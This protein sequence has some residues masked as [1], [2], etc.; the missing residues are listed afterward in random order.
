MSARR[1]GVCYSLSHHFCGLESGSATHASR[2][3][4]TGPGSP[5]VT[6]RDGRL[7]A[8]TSLGTRCELQNERGTAGQWRSLVRRGCLLLTARN[9]V[10]QVPLV[11]DVE[12]ARE[13]HA[14]GPRRDQQHSETQCGQACVQ[15]LRD[16]DH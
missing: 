16:D 2:R 8:R 5:Q 9:D 15:T 3:D 7:R 11:V 10:Q 1:N 12:P 13:P 6:D 14:E 4:R